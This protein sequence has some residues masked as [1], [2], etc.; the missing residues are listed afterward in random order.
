MRIP[1]GGK[2]KN[3]GFYGGVGSKPAPKTWTP[4]V[5]EEEAPPQRVPAKF[6]GLRLRRTRRSQM[7]PTPDYVAIPVAVVAIGLLFLLALLILG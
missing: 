6:R 3:E 5:H 2:H 4:E 7:E 1:I